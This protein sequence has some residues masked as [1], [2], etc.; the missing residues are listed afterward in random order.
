[1]SSGLESGESAGA[2]RNVAESVLSTDEVPPESAMVWINSFGAPPDVPTVLLVAGQG[3]P[4][5]WEK[6][7]VDLFESKLRNL[8]DVQLIL[9]PQ[10]PHY[11]QDFETP[12]VIESI[13]HVVFPNAEVI[14]RRTLKEKGVDTCIAQYKKIK[15]SYPKDFVR[16][17]LLN[18]LG[19]DALAGNN[20]TAAITLFKMNVAA[21]P[22][23]FNVYDSLGEAYMAAGNKPEAIKNYEKSLKMNPANT[24]AEKMLKKLKAG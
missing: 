17:R 21:Y 15:A 19:Y 10:S 24:N 11:I 20:A 7:G 6:G 22:G 1:M 2:S 9:L 12:T 3:R 8:S 13:R 5:G 14:L 18:K 4:P 23:S 16:E